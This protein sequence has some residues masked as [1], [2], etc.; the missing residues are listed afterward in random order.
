MAQKVNAKVL[1]MVLKHKWYDMIESGEKKEEYRD[2]N[3]Y[4]TMRLTT[5]FWQ[6]G[7][8]YSAVFRTSH[9]MNEKG[10]TMEAFY[11]QRPIEKIVFHR[12]YTSTTME[13]K[14]GHIELGY[15]YTPWGA[16]KNNM[17]YII[18]LKERI[19]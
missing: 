11:Y 10:R 18:P 12:G 19:R 3:R 2:F 15:G 8:G 14:A 9:V 6:E 17:V 7:N 4:W 1:H 16:P 5:L 13:W